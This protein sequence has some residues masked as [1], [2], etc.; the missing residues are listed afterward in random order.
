MSVT[1]C[2][3]LDENDVEIIE[4]KSREMGD[5]SVSAALRVIIREWDA[6][7]RTPQGQPSAT[8]E[9]YTGFPHAG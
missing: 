8:P 2:Y 1:K 7:Q 4:Q 5:S 3:I 9:R 6:R